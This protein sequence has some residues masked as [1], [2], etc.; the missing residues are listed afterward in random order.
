MTSKTFSILDYI[1]QLKPVGRAKDRF[2]CPVCEANDFTIA[3]NGKNKGAF[4]CW[5]GGC[6]PRQ[7][8]DV[9]APLDKQGPLTSV[10]LARRK[11]DLS[12]RK[13]ALKAAEV[14]S[15]A[16]EL[17]YMV[18]EKCFSDGEAFVR[19]R[20]WCKSEGHNEW[21]ATTI[22][23]G[24]MRQLESSQVTDESELTPENLKTVIESYIAE[25]DPFQRA[26]SERVI[27]RTF[28]VRGKRLDDL[29]RILLTPSDGGSKTV[30]SIVGDV[31]GEIQHRSSSNGPTGIR[32]GFLDLDAMTDG[33]Q[34]SD[35]IVVA[36][37]PS[38]GKSG[39]AVGC[40][41]G[42]ASAG[43]KIMLFSLEMGAAQLGYRMLSCYSGVE[44]SRL[45]A[46]RVSESDW[47]AI[48][49]AQSRLAE[50]SIIINDFSELTVHRIEALAKPEQPD[51]IV[52][53]Y[54]TLLDGP[55][56]SDTAIVTN[57]TKKLKILARKLNIPIILLSQLSRAVEGRSNK[58]PIMAD[59]RQSG[60]VEQD[61]DLILMLYREEYY[62]PET[63]DRGIVEVNLVK[64]RNGPTGM[65]KLLFEPQYTRF[66]NIARQT[67]GG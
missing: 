56:D 21:D 36:G 53:D 28:G 48:S 20:S 5:S 35:L 1:D 15:K 17:A 25:D 16:E 43:S 4:Q 40:A 29:G 42:A 2:H 22:L 18:A 14:K 67:I 13:A 58:R 8:M 19:L 49:R 66:R 11:L 54:C 57:N 41:L 64:H 44:I 55:G 39:F 59:L 60:S 32:S 24:L 3:L 51:L 10:Q 23:R 61:A 6:T 46:G 34:R 52:I 65:V 37:R 38:M 31:L 7:I 63:V 27:A 26:L 30:Q 33:F 62:N 9:L 12:D 50:M 47:L 45:R